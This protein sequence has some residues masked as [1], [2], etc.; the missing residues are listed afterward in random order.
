MILFVDTLAEGVHL[1]NSTVVALEPEQGIMDVIGWIEKNI[2]DVAGF[3]IV[4]IM[5][6]RGDVKRTKEWFFGCIEEFLT[7]VRRANENCLILLGAVIPGIDDA[8]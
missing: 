7:V 2:L 6:G 3:D 1:N 5:V 8:R 4:S